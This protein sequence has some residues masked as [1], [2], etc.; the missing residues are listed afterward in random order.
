[1]GTVVRLRTVWALVGVLATIVTL[2]VVG[3][4]SAAAEDVPQYCT[5]NI[6]TDY[7]FCTTVDPA[8]AGRLARPAA[9]GSGAVLLGRFYDYTDRDPAGGYFNVTAATACDTSADL[10]F[11]LGSVPSGWNDRIS[12]FQGYNN[13]SVK[14]WKNG[15]ASGTAWGPAAYADSLSTMDNQ[16]SSLT[17]Y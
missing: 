12:S 9:D 6:S 13:C 16:A 17:F 14:L 4:P 8:K 1:M 10:D 5:L 3:A 15:G 7:Y 2:G 11:T